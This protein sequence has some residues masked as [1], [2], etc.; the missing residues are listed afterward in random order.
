MGSPPLRE[1]L[2]P[3]DATAVD[4]ATI[5]AIRAFCEESPEID[6]AYVCSAERERAG[7]AP[8]RVVQLAVKLSSPVSEPED[9]R[10]QSRQLAHRLSHDYPE[11]MRRLGYSVLADRAVPA[12]EHYAV[13]VFSRT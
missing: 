2:L 9:A 5:A 13:K 10:A 4:A 1:H 6:A 11:L 7:A 12:W 8:E 3:T